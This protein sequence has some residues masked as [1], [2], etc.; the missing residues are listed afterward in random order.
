MDVKVDQPGQVKICVY[1]IAGE[2]VMKLVDKSETVG[3]YRTYWDG[4]NTHGAMVGNAV[5]FI[6]IDTPSGRQ[7]RKV[8]LLK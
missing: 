1:N 5:Y 6:V 3:N 7:T 8:I 4:R 2:L